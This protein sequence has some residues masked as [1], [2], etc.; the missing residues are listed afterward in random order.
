MIA[1]SWLLV[2]L[3]ALGALILLVGGNRTNA[4][5][6]LLGCATVI[7]NEQVASRTGVDGIVAPSFHYWKRTFF[8]TDGS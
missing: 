5:G 8:G 6:H 2:A 4:W 3:P 7:A 1:S